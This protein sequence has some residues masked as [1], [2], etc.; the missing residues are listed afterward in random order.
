MLLATINGYEIHVP[1]SGGK[2][3]KGRNKTSTIQVRKDNLIVKQFRFVV[4]NVES[5]KKA[6]TA[7]KQHAK[8][9]D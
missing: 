4:G 8:G 2:A 3:G 1:S 6:I 9:S 7:A 5:K